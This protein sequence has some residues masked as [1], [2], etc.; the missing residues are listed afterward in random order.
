MLMDI[1]FVYHN[2]HLQGLEAFESQDPH[3]RRLKESAHIHVPGL[4]SQL[5]TLMPGIYTLGG[6]RQIG[7]TTLLKQWMHQLLK[8][9]ITKPENILFLTG[10]VINDYKE[11]LNIFEALLS[12]VTKYLIIDEVSYIAGWDRAIK[13]SADA[14]IFENKIVVLTGSDLTFIKEARMTFPGRRGRADVVDFHL[15]PLSFMEYLDLLDVDLE[16]NTELNRSFESYLLHGGYMT[17]I[18]DIAKHQKILPATLLTYSDWIRGDFLKRSKQE[19]YLQEI[20][21]AIIKSYGSQ[22]SWHSLSR[23]LSVQHPQTVAEYVQLLETMDAVFIQH[24]LLEDKLSAAPKKAKKIIFTDPFIYHAV[25]SWIDK[26]YN[27]E[28]YLTNSILQSQLVEACVVSHVRR[29]YKT[30]YIKAEG[31]VDIAYID[32]NKFWPIEVK[33]TNQLREQELRQIMKYPQGKIWNKSDK[34]FELRGL[35]VSPLLRELMKF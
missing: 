27:C 10:E 13:F 15:Y 35:R 5:P 33:W 28:E 22:I 3:L 16:N 32:E 25:S 7:K 17:A 6:G 11:L 18:N 4:L 1:R 24:A 34:E 29:K 20:L 12:P 9:K 14:G 8:E 26:K 23:H 31:E 30:F 19:H 2:T 21:S